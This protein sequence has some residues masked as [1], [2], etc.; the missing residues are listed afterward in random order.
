MQAIRI[1]S[2]GDVDQLLLEECV[3]PEPGP[4][5]VQIE[6]AYASVNPVDWKICSGVLQHMF[7]CEFPA[8]LGWDVSGT[9]TAVGKNVKGFKE[10]MEV[11]SYSRDSVVKNGTYAEFVCVQEA[12]VVEKPRSLSFAQA[13]AIPLVSLTAW[14]ALYDFAQM[15]K[16]QSLLM[17]AGAGGVGNFGIQFAKNTGLTVYTTASEVNHPYIKKFGAD[18]T[19]DYKK[20][21]FT[22][23][24]QELEP[25]GVDI[26]FDA[27][28]GKTL[29]KSY[30]LVKKNGCLITIADAIDPKIAKKG[31][32]R[33][34]CVIVKPNGEQL[35]KIVN[36]FK[37]GKLQ[38]P[39]IHE[40]PLKDVKKAH[41]MSQKGHTR[42]KVVLKVKD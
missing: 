1:K 23:V 13:A 32:M 10:G 26:V 22:K 19:I 7:T 36:L 16:G 31:E 2:Y 18:V 40:M 37:E 17:H 34:A 3:T 41:L 39:E 33:T 35:Q 11:L 6:V 9:V 30:S 20:Q 8:I 38:L 27:V 4:N 14:Q 12:K 29:K 21:D 15:K 42:G 25:Q 24:I 5:E 28:G